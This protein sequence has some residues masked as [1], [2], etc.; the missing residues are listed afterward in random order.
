MNSI[1]GS[2]QTLVWCLA[3]LIAL[4]FQSAL[5]LAVAEA[6]SASVDSDSSTFADSLV[7]VNH[8]TNTV[9][10]LF[11]RHV[12]NEAERA[13]IRT[14]QES[15]PNLGVIPREPRA[16]L[17]VSFGFSSVASA[18]S[19]ST[20]TR[21]VVSFVQHPGGVFRLGSKRDYFSFAANRNLPDQ[22]R[23][24]CQHV[25]GVLK[26]GETFRAHCRG[27]TQSADKRL[28]SWDLPIAS[29]ILFEVPPAPATADSPLGLTPQ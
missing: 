10:A 28:F 9:H 16:D 8:R 2:A 5:S 29:M 22:V 6:P 17:L 20:L 3:I 26:V 13:V 1:I 12:L 7:F 25:E 19:P 24:E 11:F 14:Q 4:F 23:S 15:P 18:A 27:Q 21:Y